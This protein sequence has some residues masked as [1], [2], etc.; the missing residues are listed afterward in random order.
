MCNILFAALIAAHSPRLQRLTARNHLAMLDRQIN[1]AERTFRIVE[2]F[3]KSGY[4]DCQH[5]R[6]KRWNKT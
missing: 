5:G 2:G 4:F 1:V 6:L 3:V